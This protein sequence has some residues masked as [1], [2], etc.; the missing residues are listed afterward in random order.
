MIETNLEVNQ[1]FTQFYLLLKHIL[2]YFYYMITQ[3]LIEFLQ[4]GVAN[5]IYIQAEQKALSMRNFLCFKKLYRPT[6]NSSLA[7]SVFCKWIEQVI[8]LFVKAD[9]P[10][11]KDC[12]ILQVFPFPQ[13]FYLLVEEVSIRMQRS[14][15]SSFLL[16][17][18]AT[19][20]EQAAR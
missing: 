10:G 5:I 8:F 20:T 1:K 2:K 15:R 16:L 6:Y 11:L 13:F 19:Y 9:F 18:K 12:F 3:L 7:F 4:T 14:G 17:E